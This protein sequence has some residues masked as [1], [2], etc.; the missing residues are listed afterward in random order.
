MSEQETTKPDTMKQQFIEDL[1]VYERH[2]KRYGHWNSNDRQHFLDMKITEAKR[3]NYMK[4]AK[5]PMSR[6]YGEQEIRKACK[7]NTKDKNLWIVGSK[8]KLEKFVYDS[9]GTDR[10]HV[11]NKNNTDYW[12]GYHNQPFIIFRLYNRENRECA[13]YQIRKAGEYDPVP[14]CTCNSGKF[15]YP[16]LYHVIVLSTMTPEEY[17][18]DMINKED[19]VGGIRW[20]YD[21][22]QI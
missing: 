11:Y 3:K 9:L 21:E 8:D 5:N 7:M 17:C 4:P 13:I 6:G 18:E 10:Y 19:T 14:I 1:I 2:C 15:L 20:R 12:N 22:L 16:D